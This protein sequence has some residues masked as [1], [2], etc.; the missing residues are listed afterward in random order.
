MSPVRSGSEYD[1]IGYIDYCSLLGTLL[2]GSVRINEFEYA[3]R[4]AGGLI[5]L[6]VYDSS[7]TNHAI[8]SSARRNTHYGPQSS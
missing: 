8:M 5:P 6:R 7:T 4:D 1:V 2:F 3:I